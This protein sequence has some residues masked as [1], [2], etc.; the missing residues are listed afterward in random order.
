[1]GER[2]SSSFGFQCSGLPFLIS[3]GDLGE[4][5]WLCGHW[6]KDRREQGQR[7]ALKAETG[8]IDSVFSI[9]SVPTKDSKPTN[10]SCVPGPFPPVRPEFPLLAGFS[11]QPR[12]SS[13]KRLC[14]YQRLSSLSTAEPAPGSCWKTALHSVVL[15]VRFI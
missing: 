8:T 1:M 15:A 4:W 10:L 12:A 3:K 6:K 2:N 13:P 7:P 14:P 11:Q 9:H 5:N